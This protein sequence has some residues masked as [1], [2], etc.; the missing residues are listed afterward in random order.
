[1]I[2]LDTETSGLVDLCCYDLDKQ[3]EILEL[4]ALKI[5]D[6]FEISETLDL[7]FK[8]SRPISP[9]ATAINHITDEMCN[10]KRSF[11]YHLDEIREFFLGECCIAGANVPF[12]LGML[13]IELRR[14]GQEYKFP[15]GWYY[16][17]IIDDTQHFSGYRLKLID[18][19]ERICGKLPEDV[20]AHSALVDCIMTFRILDKMRV[21]V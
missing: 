7:F 16:T 18:I 8:P 20:N 19:Y 2:I 12:D 3:P 1:M 9:G 13:K 5:D 6:N 11:A 4:A 21:R 15:W 17:D 10:D 14:L